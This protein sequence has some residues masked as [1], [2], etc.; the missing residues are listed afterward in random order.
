MVALFPLTLRGAT[1]KRRGQRLVGPIDH[2]FGAQGVT[3]IMGP[4]GAGKTTLL[5]LL[6]GLERASGDM[7]QYACDPVQAHR[8]QSFVFQ[9]PVMMRRSVAACIAY[10]LTLRGVARAAARIKAL[11][12]AERMGL[13][14]MADRPAADLSAGEKQKLALARALITRPSLLF[15]DEPCANL[16]GRA[17]RDIEEV[18]QAAH[19]AGTRII[20][21]THDLGQ[22][23]RLGTEVMFLLNGQL[24]ETGAAGAFF[25]GPQTPEAQAHLRGDLIV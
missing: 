18:L 9:R 21:A 4:N 11:D 23:R 19:Q 13:G 25:A 8:R 2:S 17:T 5:R 20:M 14:A 22:A 1:V 3:I 6:H 7:L 16:D 24:H 12:W 15:L 10:P